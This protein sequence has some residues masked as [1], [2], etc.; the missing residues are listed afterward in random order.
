[1]NLSP[2]NRYSIPY[3]KYLDYSARKYPGKQE[4]LNGLL[5]ETLA[6]PNAG[7]IVLPVQEYLLE[8]FVELRIDEIKK[9]YS[10][11]IERM[12]YY[13][14]K[15]LDDNVDWTT[16]RW[17]LFDAV[18]HHYEQTL[19]RMPSTVRDCKIIAL[20]WEGGYLVDSDEEPFM[21]NVVGYYRDMFLEERKTLS[22]L[23]EWITHEASEKGTKFD[24]RAIN[25]ILEME[26]LFMMRQKLDAKYKSSKLLA[27]YCA[28]SLIDGEQA[29]RLSRLDMDGLLFD[30]IHSRYGK[31]VVAYLE[32]SV[33]PR[34]YTKKLPRD[35]RFLIASKLPF[36]DIYSLSR[37]TRDWNIFSVKYNM[38]WQCFYQNKYLLYPPTNFPTSVLWCHLF[39]YQEAVSFKHIGVL[40]FFL[41]RFGN[42]VAKYVKFKDFGGKLKRMKVSTT[43]LDDAW[44]KILLKLKKKR[45]PYKNDIAKLF[46]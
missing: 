5:Q 18:W 46:G 42:D 8:K 14:T 30:V 3:I 7:D 32:C 40:A 2:I 37:T 45:A 16:I 39:H 11:P 41:R 22:Q 10:N 4:L 38:D 21:D 43:E 24:F 9:R 31:A 35:L 23:Y 19:P 44:N 1:M 33:Q 20:M 25:P 29:E 13:G 15:I 36:K 28:Q 12:G 6:S 27:H 26:Y 17:E 34:D